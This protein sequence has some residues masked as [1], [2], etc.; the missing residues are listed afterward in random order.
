[1]VYLHLRNTATIWV[2]LFYALIIL[3]ASLRFFN[4]VNAKNLRKLIACKNYVFFAK[5]LFHGKA[6]GK[7]FNIFIHEI[8]FFYIGLF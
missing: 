1:M 6:Y 5:R 4:F 2:G 3:F 7:D 8:D